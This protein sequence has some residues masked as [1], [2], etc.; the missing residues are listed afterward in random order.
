MKQPHIQ[1]KQFGLSLI[2]L[3]VAMTLGLMIT[4][5]LGYIMVGSRATYRTQDASARV[6]DTGRFA[7]EY[8]TRELRAAGRTGDMTLLLRGQQADLD[9]D[10]NAG[11]SGNVDI[12][13]DNDDITVRYQNNDGSI[14]VNQICYDAAGRELENNCGE[15]GGNQPI[16][17]GVT[18]V[19]FRY[20]ANDGT[21]GDAA[22]ANTVAV[23]MCF[24][25]RSQS[26]GVV[27][28]AQTM[29][30]CAGNLVTQ[31]DTRLYRTFA[32]VVALRNRINAIP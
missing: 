11:Y 19:R 30:N 7:I 18:E 22:N 5:T 24:M 21:W 3:M 8:I 17:E 32:T 6:Q 1:S 14:A 13:G 10:G 27:N 20:L 16:A 2:E 28:L 9:E 15:A 29:R 26:S 12:T 4:T 31:G 23:E 25:L